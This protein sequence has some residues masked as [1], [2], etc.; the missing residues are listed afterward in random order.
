MHIN[1]INNKGIS[2]VEI[3]TALAI[4]S[5]ILLGVMAFMNGGSVTY[6]TATTQ[7]SLQDEIQETSNYIHDL[8]Q[9]SMEVVYDDSLNVLYL[10]MPI[11]DSATGAHE[12]YYICYYDESHGVDASLMNK[13][14]VGQEE[15]ND[16]NYGSG[17]QLDS[18]KKASYCTQNNLLASEIRNFR[19]NIERNSDGEPDLV[20]VGMTVRKNNSDRAATISIR[21]RNRGGSYSTPANPT[22]TPFY[23]VITGFPYTPED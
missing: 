3:L 20:H 13:I 4:S 23:E 8:V 7:I 22:P 16:S 12:V 21:P 18:T 15:V 9:R 5:I 6:R 14:F 1:R 2:L 10:F 11:K 19:V 17:L